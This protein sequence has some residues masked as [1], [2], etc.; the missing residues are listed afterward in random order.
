[1]PSWL[2]FLLFLFHPFNHYIYCEQHL[3][4]PSHLHLSSNMCVIHKDVWHWEVNFQL[5]HLLFKPVEAEH[6]F[7][8]SVYSRQTELLLG[9]H[10][11]VMKDKYGKQKK[12]VGKGGFEFVITFMLVFLLPYL[13]S[14]AEE[15]LCWWDRIREMS[16]VRRCG[17]ETARG[18]SWVVL[19]HIF[20][21]GRG[22]DIL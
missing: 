22:P 1:M 11:H 17:M 12:F 8:A 18:I 10:W 13:S 5:L 6:W 9:I 19:E 15:Y 16:E 21:F 4:L 3:K 2:S 14:P 20:N 7:S